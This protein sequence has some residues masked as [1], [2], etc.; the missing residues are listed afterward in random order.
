MS[1][2]PV[3]GDQRPRGPGR[4]AG[5]HRVAVIG[6]GAIARDH[7][8]AFAGVHGLRLAHVV[9]RHPERAAALA[10]LA[11]GATWSTD[12]ATAWSDDVDV[13]AVCTSPESHADLSV[14]A[15]RAGRAVLLEKPAALNVA[16]A[17]RILAAAKA[18]DR[19]LLVAQTARFQPVHLEI[20]KAV[21][22]GAIGTPRLA[23]LTW[24]TG[25]VWSGGWRGWQLDSARSGG[26]VAHNGVHAL[27]LLTWLMDDEPVRVFARPTNTWAAGMPTPD[28][29]QIL[30][31]F[32]GGALATIELCYALVQRGT[33]VRRLMLSG[34]SGTLHHSSE[35]EPRAHA[36]SPV[37]PASIDGAMTEQ[38]RH[39]RDVL[40]GAA[41][42]LTAPHQIRAA[43]AAALAAQLSADE[44]RPV[45]VKEVC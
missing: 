34:T 7:V 42:P 16:D 37:A 43:L 28:S 32:A 4:Q 5:E 12:P 31:R 14:A 17:D 18:A 36:A 25:H 1:P 45:D 23:H 8:T 30:V 2:D 11:E 41:A 33:F 21:A 19:P 26:H 10:A 6:A 40:D 9:D 39:L 35:D 24:Y 3:T 15:L 22:E 13:T 38:T 27:D 29:F 20:A 44:G